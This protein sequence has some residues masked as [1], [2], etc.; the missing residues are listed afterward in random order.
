MVIDLFAGPGGWD[1]AAREL[2]IEPLGI[3][4]DDAACA[5]RE[6]AGLRTL[7]AD[8]AALDPLVV[9]HE[10]FPPA[11]TPSLRAG[12]NDHDVAR[13]AD[14]PA[15]LNDVS[16]IDRVPSA[17]DGLIASPPCQA[18]S[19][20]GKG[21]GRKAMRVYHDAIVAWQHGRAP[22]YA[23]LDEACADE[24]AHLVLE[25][26]RWAYALRPRWI[27]CE[28]VE[29]VLPLWEEMAGALRA[30]GYATW[31]GV[32]SA[33]RYGVPQTRRRAILLASLDG[34]V[35]EPPATHARY[36]APRRKAEETMGLFDAPEPERIVLP[37]DRGLLPWVSMAEALGWGMSARPSVSVA[38]GGE[39]RRGAKPLGGGSGS[40]RTIERE[41]AEGAWTAPAP[42]VTAGGTA[43]GG[44]EV[45]GRGGRERIMRAGHRPNAAVRRGDEPA[46]TIIGGHDTAN[47]VWEPTEDAVV[48][49][50]NFSAVARDPDGKR[51]K[52]GSVPYERPIDAPAP[53]VDRSAS[54]WKVVPTHYDE[55]APTV[56]AEKLANEPGR[57]DP[58][59]SG[60]QQANAIRVTEEEA[61]VLQG[62]PA[63]YPVQGTRSKR[64]QQIGNAIPPP[65]ALACLRVVAR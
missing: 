51:S 23:K 13:R 12:T 43:S 44:V 26:L 59:V 65:L 63:D 38:S 40:Q 62:F 20:A 7:Q 55:P 61:L 33:E 45:F 16:W 22:D 31:T 47:R 15:R 58:N 54:G 32:L 11:S 64:F 17:L 5:T 3:E 53:T 18:F 2:G 52:A 6:A 14:E 4:F 37:E 10:H 30:V 35:G 34:P 56:C 29:P 27:A 25:P 50:N 49:T 1:L 60:S 57:H 48:R 9:M 21:A 39:E 36:V 8:V 19:M 24:R 46:P 41:Q 42:T 28:Q